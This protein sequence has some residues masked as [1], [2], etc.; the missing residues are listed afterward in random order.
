MGLSSGLHDVSGAAP[1]PL[2][3]LA[4]LASA[5]AGLFSVVSSPGANAGAGANPNT[6]TSSSA[7]I[8]GLDALVALAD[9]L[10]ASYVSTADGATAA[11]AGDEPT[12]AECAC[13]LSQRASAC[14]RSP[15][16]TPSTQPAWTA[17][18]TRAG[19]PARSAAPGQPREMTMLGGSAPA[20][21]PSRG[22]PVSDHKMKIKE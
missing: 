1:L 14:A 22:S 16:G 13:R 6:T 18:S 4:S 20:R 2:L 11:A 17:G 5:L 9:F 8:A 15:A 10:A 12:T 19:S 3:L 7:R 21:T